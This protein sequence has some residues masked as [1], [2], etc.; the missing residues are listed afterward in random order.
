MAMFGTDPT[1]LSTSHFKLITELAR[2]GGS[3]IINNVQEHTF[4]REIDDLE[5]V[6]ED[7]F[8]SVSQQENTTQKV[9]TVLQCLQCKLWNIGWNKRTNPSKFKYVSSDKEETWSS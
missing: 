9:F 1:V 3:Q 7:M 8:A 4:A 6:G 2:E 5:K